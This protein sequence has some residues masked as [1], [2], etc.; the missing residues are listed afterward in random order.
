MCK[1]RVYLMGIVLLVGMIGTA[2]AVTTN[3]KGNAATQDWSLSGNWTDGVPGSGDTAQI[4]DTYQ[5]GPIVSSSVSCDKIQLGKDNKYGMNHL[6][7]VSGGSLTVSGDIN[8][9]ITADKYRGS[10]T[11][12]GGSVNCLNLLVGMEGFGRLIITGGTVEVG[13]NLKVP[14]DNADN[15]LGHIYLRG[16]TLEAA[17]LERASGADTLID[18]TEGTLIIDG[19]V[20]SKI[21]TWV[22]AGRITAYGGPGTVSYDY[23]TTNAGQTTVTASPPTDPADGGEDA[24]V[25]MTN[26]NVKVQYNLTQG[27]ADF[28]LSD[29]KKINHFF[30][31]VKLPSYVTSQDYTS[32]SYSTSGTV[33]TITC[34]GGGNPTMKQIFD[35]AGTNYFRV[36]VKMEGEDLSSNWMAPVVMENEGGLDIGSYDDTR[37]LYMRFGT[38]FKD[39]PDAQEMTWTRRSFGCSAFYDNTSRDGLVI[40]AVRHDVWKSAVEYCADN[41]KLN[42][43][44]AYGGTLMD[45]NERMDAHGSITGDTIESPEFFVG[46]Y[47]DWRDGMEKYAD[48][49]VS[50][51]PAPTL[52]ETSN[53]GVPL[54]WKHYGK[55]GIGSECTLQV[56]KD[57]SDYLA[58][59]L[60][61]D[62]FYNDKDT[63]Y[64]ILG[65]GGMSHIGLENCAEFVSYVHTNNQ[66]AGFYFQTFCKGGWPFDLDGLVEGS[67]TYTWNDI[68]LRNAYNN[69]IVDRSNRLCLDPTH[70]G[71]KE[72]I[73]YYVDLWE[74]WGADYFREDF[75]QTG[76]Y[77]GIDWHDPNVT[78]GM[79]AYAQGMNYLLDK[80]NGKMHTNSGVS[81]NFPYVFHSKRTNPDAR[82]EMDENERANNALTSMWW[83]ATQGLT[84]WMDPGQIDFDYGGWSGHNP[85]VAKS[86]VNC[87]VIHGGLIIN[88]N[89]L[90]K[91][92]QKL[93][94]EEYLT[95]PEVMA[96]ARKCKTFKPI[97]NNFRSYAADAFV[98]ND[99]G[100]YYLAVFNYK[101]S[102]SMTKSIDLARAG[103]SGST[104]YE[105]TDLWDGSTEY[106][107]GTWSV[108]LDG[109]ESKLVKLVPGEDTTPPANPTGLAATAGD[110]QV[111]LDW[112]NNTEGDL[113][114][115]NVYRSLTS[116][117]GYSKINGSLVIPSEYIDNTVNNGTTYYYKA[118]AVDELE[119]ESGYSN[120]DSAIP[121]SE[122]LYFNPKHDV[123]VK[124]AAPTTNYS[125]KNYLRIRELDG[126]DQHS[127][128]KFVVEGV[129]GDVTNATL[130]MYSNTAAQNVPVYESVSYLWWQQSLTWNNAPGSTGDALDTQYAGV[131]VWVEWDV[132]SL[133]TNNA[134]YSV[135]LKGTSEDG[136]KDLASVEDTTHK[137]ELAVTYTPE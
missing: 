81:A 17:V 103:L 73:D 45:Y 114:G 99:S 15:T 100:T 118:T 135:V 107:T 59:N 47:D 69:P 8:L 18:I 76:M 127:Y 32:H 128:L 34:S 84:G 131:G 54:G 79:A 134:T 28:Y 88:S 12:S 86:R 126:S 44:Y 20:T 104:S 10:M 119:N 110:S 111:S 66:K 106:A 2:L 74:T 75:V 95:D 1:K 85:D 46:F 26:G 37:A 105:I 38:G 70:P 71:T 98:L 35:L 89:D 63:L 80:A 57:M 61:N 122:T 58:D 136:T 41:D 30:S 64:C 117:S 39:R 97:E 22:S 40:G 60:Q 9:G 96:L 67:E 11:V 92:G 5:P 33:T 25:T 130:K 52:D 56:A 6:D 124:E 101:D 94:V 16:G 125:S 7:V 3:W 4:D 77:E 21:S 62:N 55:D 78:T 50:I 133:I 102:Q 132:T 29:V 72:R 42:T 129:T 116:G 112:N 68:A 43:L 49:M 19:D 91:S 108:N 27:R 51:I 13:N 90:R 120:E 82:W 14:S 24:F 123:F 137:P 31:A 36:K 109:G 48:V 115:Y 53:Q 121:G 65:A 83:Y 93:L 113:D 87:G 23:N